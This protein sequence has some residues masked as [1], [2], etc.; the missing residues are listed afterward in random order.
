MSNPLKAGHALS[1]G[2][3]HVINYRE[4]DVG[5]AV[6]EATGGKGV[7]AV[8]EVDLTNNARL[9]PAVLKARAMVTVYGMSAADAV[10]PSLWLMRN[11]ISLRFLLIY[12][13]PPAARRAALKEL[14]QHVA[15]GRLSPTIGRR[16]PLAAIAEAHDT[17]ERGEV[18]GS[19]VL[20]V[21]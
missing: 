17:V 2:A 20:D 6:S 15:S 13:I 21:G 5:A 1:A 16:L 12:E 7:D 19:V 10:L 14:S 3:D 9:Y 8:L 18:I 4:H 11:S